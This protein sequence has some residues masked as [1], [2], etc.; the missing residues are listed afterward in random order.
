MRIDIRYVSSFT[1]DTEVADSHNTLRACPTTDARQRLVA[2]HVEVDP[3]ADVVTTFDYWGTR[4]DSFG[5]NAPHTRLTVAATSTVE[6]LDSP[7]PDDS[8]HDG[9]I[10]AMWSEFTSPSQHVRW[11]GAVEEFAQDAVSG[12]AAAPARALALMKAVGAHMTYTH[13]ATEIGTSVAEV[14]ANGKGVCQDYSHL[15]IAAARCV[16]IPARYVSGY[17]YSKDSTKGTVPQEEEIDV[18]THAWVEIEIPGHG[19]WGLDPTNQLV[20]GERHVKIGHGRDYEDVTPLRGVFHGR[21]SDTGLDVSVKM[22]SGR[23]AMYSFGPQPDLAAMIRS[24]QQ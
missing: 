8:P 10:S 20:V 3:A 17:L 5:V 15:M 16:G 1:Y 23:L 14:L 2:Y 21:G 6:T 4:V 22:S 11:D 18:K 19:W 12:A 7:A 24:H 9:R 13:G